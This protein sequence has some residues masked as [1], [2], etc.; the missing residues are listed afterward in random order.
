MFSILKNP[1]AASKDL[2]EVYVGAERLEETL[3]GEKSEAYEALMAAQIECF[4]NEKPTREFL[5][6]QK[7]LET[8]NTKIE[9]CKFGREQLKNRLGERLQVEIKQRLEQITK[10]LA[11]LSSEEKEIQEAFLST[12]AKA[13]VLKEQ[14]KGRSLLSDSQGFV[15]A[16]V[17]SLKVEIHLLDGIDGAFYSERIK[18]YRKELQVGDFSRSITGRRDDLVQERGKLERSLQSD[19]LK[20]A[21]ELLNRLIPPPA[22]E[23]AATEAR[24]TQTFIQD[25]DRIGPVDYGT[26]R[27]LPYRGVG[28]IVAEREMNS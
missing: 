16:G 28:E 27:E 18:H 26:G 15:T 1:E 9:G 6:A 11:S 3:S 14:I 22:P 12:A 19:P 17:P 20:S 24:K 10:E 25:Y 2:A 7:R 23:P 4:D 21:E 8:I 13:A 5:S